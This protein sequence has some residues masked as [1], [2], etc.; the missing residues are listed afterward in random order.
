MGGCGWFFVL[1]RRWEVLLFMEENC[2][3]FKEKYL[4]KNE[5]GE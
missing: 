3:W 5:M 2:Y 4:R 1:L